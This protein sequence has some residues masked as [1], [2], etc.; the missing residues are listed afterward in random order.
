MRIMG[1]DVGTKR[2]GVALSDEGLCIASPHT[3]IER[4]SLVKDMDRI[5][6]LAEEYSVELIVSGLP[7]NMNGS[8]GPQAE[9]V[10]RFIEKLERHTGLKVETWDER[11]STVA[12]TKVLIKGGSSR[13]DRK[14]A[15]DKLSASYILQSY[16]DRRAG[17]S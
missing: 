5:K 8:S 13:R 1:L 10:L 15:V 2:I 9:Y 12:V 6:G 3:Q 17:S 16:L 14:K 4:V 7:L 11:L